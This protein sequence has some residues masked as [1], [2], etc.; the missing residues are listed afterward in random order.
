M[1]ILILL[2]LLL[3]GCGIKKP[4]VSQGIVFVFKTPQVRFS[5][6]GFLYRSHDVALEGYGG[7][8]GVFRLTLS[9]RVCI[10]GRCMDFEE[11]NRR[12][13]SPCYPD[14][15]LKRVLLAR[16]LSEDGLKKTKDGFVQRLRSGCFDIVY[17]ISGSKIL[18]KDH[19]N[20]IFIKVRSVDG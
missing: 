9:D 17:S 11:F 4:P 19:K 6:T 7:G 2:V 3:G 12:F 1:R 8:D 16:P 10:N 15:L 13:L 5:G 14:D 20:H 18:F